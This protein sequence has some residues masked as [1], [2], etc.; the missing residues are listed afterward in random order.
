[1]GKTMAWNSEIMPKHNYKKIKFSNLFQ[2]TSGLLANCNLCHEDSS[3]DNSVACYDMFPRLV[4]INL[5]TEL[6]TQARVRIKSGHNL[7]TG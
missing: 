2:I 4:S 5:W 7:A 6:F 3:T 1:M